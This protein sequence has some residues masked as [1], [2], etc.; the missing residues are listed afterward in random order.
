MSNTQHT[1]LA[2]FLKAS[3]LSFLVMGLCVLTSA[4]ATIGL[5]KATGQGSSVIELHPAAAEASL[6]VPSPASVVLPIRDP[7][8]TQLLVGMLLILC[9]FFIHAWYVVR[10]ERQGGAVGNVQRKR[11]KS[12]MKKFGRGFS[13]LPV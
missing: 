13:R 5:A 9:G 2:G 10:F 4:S 11:K 8:E 3:T 12:V 6:G 1:H 7:A